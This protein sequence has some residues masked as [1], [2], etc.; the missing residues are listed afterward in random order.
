MYNT[1]GFN[2]L[3]FNVGSE[4]DSE[5][6]LI[7]NM[8]ASLSGM[9]LT[10]GNLF[11]TQTANNSFH[12]ATKSA[13]GVRLG[14]VE[15]SDNAN[16]AVA[17]YIYCYLMQVMSGAFGA[18]LWCSED[19]CIVTDMSSPMMDAAYLS[20]N[21]TIKIAMASALAKKASA[22]I[23]FYQSALAMASIV[24]AQVASSIFDIGYTVLNITIKPGQ[25]LVIDSDN[26]VV[27]LD[28]DDAIAA[29]SGIWPWLSRELFDIQ[30][31][32]GAVSDLA[33]SVLYTERYL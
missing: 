26:Y 31:S 30:V 17:G 19:I 27:L 20:L 23:D 25:T 7:E 21:K 14:L 18:A 2:K 15:M 29:H 12:A 10:G 11:V 33:V 6:R 8:V 1:G 4:S 22:G 13:A 16:A 24:D 9:V 32:S 3:R 28:G 5:V